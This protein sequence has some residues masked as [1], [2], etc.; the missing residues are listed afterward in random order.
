MAQT[1]DRGLRVLEYLGTAPEGFTATEVAQY[2]GVHRSIAARLLVTLTHRGFA[3]KL[4]DGR[5]IVGTSVFR[6]ARMVARDLVSVAQPMLRDATDRTMA[7]SVLHIADGDE[8]VTLLSIEPPSATFRVGMRVGARGPLDLAAHGVA[9]LAGREPVEGERAEIARSRELGYA[10]TTGVVVPGYTGIS[11]PVVVNGQ[12]D[13]SV[14][15][16]VPDSRASELGTL[17][18]EVLGLAEALSLAAG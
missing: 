10:V 9:I 18:A 6:L 14:G 2:I 15:L 16:V 5:Y 1:L 7:T 13:A 11:A 4:A 17:T 3:S 8:V 12:V